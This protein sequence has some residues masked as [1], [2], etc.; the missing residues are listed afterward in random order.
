MKQFSH[1]KIKPDFYVGYLPTPKSHRKFLLLVIPM[2]FVGMIVLSMALAG[3]QR[4][5]GATIVQTGAIESWSGTVFVDPYPMIITDE[6][7]IYFIMGI[8]KFGVAQRVAQ[9]DGLRCLV[10]GWRLAR[11]D[12]RGIQLAP[13]PDAIRGDPSGKAAVIKP[14]VNGGEPVRLVGEIVDG[15]CYI[16]AMKPGDGK[17]HKA[18]AILCIDAGLPPL[19]VSANPNEFQTLPLVRINGKAELTDEIL[20]LAGEP[21][22]IDGYLRSVGGLVILDTTPEQVRRWTPSFEN[23]SKP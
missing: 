2:L 20:Q 6:G 14:E 4:D 11:N 15:K 13:E 23:E 19:F 9:F 21:V 12:R 10:D 22:I 1:E 16:G 5:P 3:R 7:D 18:C 17:G 8:G